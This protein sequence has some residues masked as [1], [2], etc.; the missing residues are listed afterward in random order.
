MATFDSLSAPFR[1]ERANTYHEVIRAGLGPAVLK[2]FYGPYAS[3]LWGVP[4]TALHG[5]IARRR[6]AVSSAAKLLGKLLRAATGGPPTFLYPRNGYGQ[7]VDRLVA[8]CEG[9]GVSMHLGCSVTEIQCVAEIHSGEVAPVTLSYETAEEKTTT[10]CDRVFWTAAPHHLLDVVRE[11]GSAPQFRPRHRAVVLVYLT[12][13]TDR[14]TP[15]DAHYFPELE[16][17]PARV[18]EPKNYRDADDPS[19]RTVLCAE[20]VCDPGDDVWSASPEHLTKLTTEA[21][22]SA[23][24]PALDVVGVHIERLPA[25]Y[26]V[27]GPNDMEQM[28][29]VLQR[30]HNVPNATVL[31]RQGLLVADN[32]HHVLDMAMTA[33]DCLGSDGGWNETEWLRALDRFERNVVED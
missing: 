26:P 15:Y 2:W 7:I 5:D 25:V 27:V 19:G 18:S 22:A 28:Q 24:L 20:I 3:K 33:V 29:L 14:Y 13:A 23:D 31:G 1:R 32:L 6:V 11:T 30:A 21:L 8:E 9:A 16:L 10:T 17:L 12:L 4:A